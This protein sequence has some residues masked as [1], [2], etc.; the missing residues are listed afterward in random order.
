MR[1]STIPP[2]KTDS[3]EIIGLSIGLPLCIAGLFF[4]LAVLCAPEAEAS[5]LDSIIT[6]G[7]HSGAAMIGGTIALGFMLAREFWRH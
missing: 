7:R 5:T 2:F 6:A 1:N 4:W 3:R